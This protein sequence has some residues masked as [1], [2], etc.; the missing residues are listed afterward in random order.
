MTVYQI[1]YPKKNP[2]T[3]REIKVS[4]FR[5]QVK[6]KGKSHSKLFDTEHEAKAWVEEKEKK[7]KIAVQSFK[8][9]D[10]FDEFIKDVG[11]YKE[12][13]NKRSAELRKYY[14]ERGA[15]IITI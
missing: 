1:S 14:E 4:K 12:E 11:D 15:T 6:H 10:K 9:R 3:K 13:A 8:T 2:L 5:A 7:I